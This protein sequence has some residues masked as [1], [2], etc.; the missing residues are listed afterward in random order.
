MSG[1]EEVRP[2][3]AACAAADPDATRLLVLFTRAD[4]TSI[5]HW[6]GPGADS[7]SE[8]SY[9]QKVSNSEQTRPEN[10]LTLTGSK[11]KTR[12]A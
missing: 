9:C 2:L 6:A 4:K 5:E 10:F 8:V 3:L 1:L 12:S 11:F 7:V